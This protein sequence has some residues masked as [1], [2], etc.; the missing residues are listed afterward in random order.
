MG[1][2]DVTGTTFKGTTRQDLWNLVR[3]V[4]STHYENEGN[5]HSVDDL[6]EVRDGVATIA[7]AFADIYKTRWAQLIYSDDDVIVKTKRVTFAVSDL[8][9]HA[10]W[11][12]I[13]EMVAA[14]ARETNQSVRKVRLA[15]VHDEGLPL[16]FTGKP[17]VVHTKTEGETVTFYGVFSASKGGELL[18][19]GDTAADAKKAAEKYMLEKMTHPWGSYTQ[20]FIRK[21]TQRGNSEAQ[22]SSKVV[23]SRGKIHLDVEVETVRNGATA[24]GWAV[25]LDCHH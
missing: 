19:K 15:D 1:H 2:H 14:W 3:S 22:F 6:Y 16:G 10:N 12:Q 24:K 9:M 11:A 4:T 25:C 20:T 5:F 7:Q 17:K 23:L 13:D 18:A 8:S 21:V